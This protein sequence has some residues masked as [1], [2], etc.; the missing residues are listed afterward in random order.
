MEEREIVVRDWTGPTP[1]APACKASRG[2]IRAPIELR[3]SVPPASATPASWE[4]AVKLRLDNASGDCYSPGDR[5]RANAGVDMHVNRI[6][7][8]GCCCAFWHVDARSLRPANATPP[9]CS[10]VFAKSRAAAV[11]P[12]ARDC[13]YVLALS[14]H[15][16][17]RLMGSLPCVFGTLE[18]NVLGPRVCVVVVAAVDSGVAAGLADFLDSKPYVVDWALE[19]VD[20]ETRDKINGY[21]EDCNRGAIDRYWRELE[22][23]HQGHAHRDKAHTSTVAMFR[24]VWL[25]HAMARGLPGPGPKLIARGRIDGSFTDRLDWE[26][27][28]RR[29]DG[30]RILAY[31]AAPQLFSQRTQGVPDRKSCIIDDQFAVGPP[32]LMDGYASVF[33]DFEDFARTLLI[34]RMDQVGHANERIL[35]Q[36]LHYR[37]VEWAR[38]S[39][40]Q[41]IHSFRC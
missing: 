18:K 23:R 38:A 6:D 24:K 4:E 2:A 1:Q 34:T 33:P 14:G 35:V 3:E 16:N 20:P 21:V 29:T 22:A 17:P 30:K 19:H 41:R 37:G 25:A 15:V 10:Q 9:A 13:D 40:V 36:H 12:A 39:T 28:L 31:D 8:G 26:A 32:E 11:R 5:P 27:V 7:V